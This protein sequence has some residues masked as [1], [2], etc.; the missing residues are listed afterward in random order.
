M[1]TTARETRKNQTR[2][3]LTEA[4]ISLLASEGIEAL[5]ADRIAEAAGVSR[6]TLFNYF[7]RV[8]DVLTATIEGVTS[9][10]IDA[11]VARPAEESLRDAAMA[12]IEE[13]IDSPAFAQVRIL[14]RAAATSPATRR[15]VLEFDDRQCRALEEGLR[16]RLGEDADPI[17]VAGLA[18]A[19]FGV[20]CAVTRLAVA[21]TDDDTRAAELHKQWIRRGLD[22]LF[23]GFDESGAR[24]TPTEEN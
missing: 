13:L 8:E 2:D 5:T 4:A 10:T 16:R 17:F 21:A 11:I 6:R 12:V 9:E 20:L 22:L 1:P 19:A 3:A 15:F 18:A 24:P 14:E 23:A 7:P